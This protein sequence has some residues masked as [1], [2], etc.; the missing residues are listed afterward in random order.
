VGGVTVRF[1]GAGDAFGNGG[2]FQ[3]CIVL[4]AEG[5]ERLTLVDCGAS[6]LVALKRLGIDPGAV[7]AIVLSHLHGDHFGGIPFFVLDAQFTRREKPLLIAGPPG[8]QARVRASMEVFF[9]GSSAVQRRFELVFAEYAG[10]AG[11]AEIA[12]G[13]FAVSAFEVV[14]ASGAPAFALR[15][16][17]GDKVVAYSGDTEWTA[18]LIGAARDADLFVCE[19]YTFERPTKFHLSYAA[20]REHRAEL[21]ARRVILTHMGPEMLA[22]LG[23][24]PDETAADGLTL[25][26]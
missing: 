17:C 3:T 21:G 10:D 11:G 24:V 26:L 19:A 16:R 15:L 13:A 23:G 1:A 4:Q 14:H 7:D 12:A 6:S 20:L 25:T 22:H 5:E 9:P 8:T 2:R 18:A